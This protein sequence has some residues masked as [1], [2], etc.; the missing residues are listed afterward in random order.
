MMFEQLLIIFGL[1]FIFNGV[2]LL[3]A[4]TKKRRACTEYVE[5]SVTGHESSKKS[6]MEGINNRYHRLHP[7]LSYTINDTCYR[8]VYFN[9]IKLKEG[10]KVT[11]YFNPADM[12]QYYLKED[13]M[14]T[15]SAGW[16]FC[17]VVG[18]GL[19]L[20]YFIKEFIP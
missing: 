5:G 1:G 4:K 9:F 19:I 12:E 3:V 7:V 2:Y 6:Y 20:S 13:K 8:R 17:F 15:G 10:D 14:F 18:I 16:I 11:V